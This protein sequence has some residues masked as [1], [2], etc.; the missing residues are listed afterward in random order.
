MKTY[1]IGK[2]FLLKNKTR[3]L[4]YST[5]FKTKFTVDP[6][7]GMNL[8]DPIP[9]P[10]RLEGKV[11]LITGGS[12]GIGRASVELF[13]NSGVEGLMIA[14]LDENNGKLL[15]EKINQERKG[16]VA[17]FI[18]TDMTNSKQIEAM[19]NETMKTFGK[20]NIM[21]N[22]AG[23][24]MM[25]DDGPTNTEDHVW[26]LTMNVN[27]KAVF[28]CCKY[29]IPHILKSGGGSIINTASLVAVMGSATPQI[30][31]T[32]SKGAVLAMTR[33]MAIIYA[34]QNLRINSLCPGP[35]RTPLLMNFLNTEE[36]LK[37]RIV[38]LP[39]G[40]F[41]EAK[42]IAQAVAFLASDESTYITGNTFL[43]DG[44]LSQAYVTPE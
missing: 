9:N 38:H 35:I 37:R 18:K 43:V 17:S 10:R 28:T 3:N 15:V 29:G 19:V 40:R 13:A 23:I 32:A 5:N 16:K 44:G 34:K 7:G 31:Y 30:A 39:L 1:Q 24:M 2:N 12:N 42:E 20:L 41:G 4:F 11:A 21:F 36:K 33:E 8:K 6:F 14:D 27:A 25:D 26:D 22:N